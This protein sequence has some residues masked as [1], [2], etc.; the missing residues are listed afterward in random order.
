MLALIA[1]TVSY[2]H[3]HLLDELPGQPGWIAAP[4]PLSVDGMIVAAST[5]LLPDSRK[6]IFFFFFFLVGCSEP[7]CECGGCGA[8]GDGPGDCV[9]AVALADRW[10]RAA[11]APGPPRHR[12]LCVRAAHGSHRTRRRSR[13][14]AHC[15]ESGVVDEDL[16]VT[17]PCRATGEAPSSDWSCVNRTRMSTLVGLSHRVTLDA[18]RQLHAAGHFGQGTG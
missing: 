9:V 15:G 11:D 4:T 8:Y 10:G 5:T 12:V 6:F 16:A 1:G 14:I 17:W 13:Q 18:C 7:G 2:L 3:M